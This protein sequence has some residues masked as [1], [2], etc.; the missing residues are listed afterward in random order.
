MEIELMLNQSKKRN[1]IVEGKI[2][3]EEGEDKD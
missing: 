1:L 3:R 2:K